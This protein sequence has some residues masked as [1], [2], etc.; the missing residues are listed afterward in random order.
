MKL[1]YLVLAAAA[2]LAASCSPK[3]PSDPLEVSLCSAIAGK[4]GADAQV[5]LEGFTRTD[6]V[7][8]AQLLDL[9]RK[10]FELKLAQDTKFYEKYK[11]EHMGVNAKKHQD[12]MVR[13][14]NILA[15]FNVLEAG[16]AGRMDEIAYYDCAFSGQVKSAAG[17]MPLD[18]YNAVVTPS[19]E[20]VAIQAGTK[21]I[22]SGLGKL[23]PGYTE[24]IKGEE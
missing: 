13:T 12:A 18:G 1:R 11:S 19:G 9:R 15:G 8:F 14:K 22:H 23:I 5:S 24:L 16:L 21:N 7:S 17:T 20:V 2:I 10:A 4:A 6:S 3:A